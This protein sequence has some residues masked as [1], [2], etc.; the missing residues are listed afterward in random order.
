MATLLPTPP[1]NQNFTTVYAPK[2]PLLN[3]GDER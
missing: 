2:R 1:N 3:G